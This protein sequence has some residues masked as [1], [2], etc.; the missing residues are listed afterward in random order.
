MIEHKEIE[1]RIK[2]LQH[3]MKEKCIDAM[4]ISSNANIIYLF[5]EVFSGV[6][7][8]TH[9]DSPLFFIRRPQSYEPNDCIKYI[10]KIEDLAEFTDVSKFNVVAFEL[11]EMPYNDII[12]KKNIFPNAKI[13]NAS[14]VLRQARM[15]KTQCEIEEIRHY[16]QIH[17]NVYNY[18]KDLYTDGMTDTQFQIEIERIMRLNGSVGLFRAFGPNMEIFMGNLISGDNA[19]EP[20]PY[21][22]A[23]GG[24][25]TDALPLGSNGMVMREGTSVMVDMAGN[26][27]KYLTD[28]TRTFS[29]GNLPDEAYR[30]HEIS[31]EMHKNIMQK[32][33]VGD[34]CAD[35]YNSCMEMVKQHNVEQYFMGYR[36]KAA[37]VGHGLGIQINELPVLTSKSR[38]VIQENMLIA[39]EPKFVV[40]NIGAVGIE[41]TY[42]VT[43]NGIEN[44]TIFEEN[45][46][47]L[48]N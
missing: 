45:I 18:I 28:M 31:I 39:F 6:I 34:R 22:F 30:M 37:F 40:P 17:S 48:K 33:K 25:G 46:I 10:R 43:K 3:K 36:Q 16:A 29:I 47:N 4:L 26:Y 7:L 42:L 35:I 8:I 32:T 19:S 14:S 12:R 11:D 44:L 21:D 41:N 27:G 15:I 13:E 9:S 23:M 20:S 1:T 24:K 2:P 38:D 5:G